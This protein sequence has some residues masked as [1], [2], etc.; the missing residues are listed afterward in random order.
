MKNSIF[1]LP[2]VLFLT[3]F[4]LSCEFEKEIQ[5]IDNPIN[6]TAELSEALDDIVD[7]TDVPGFAVTVV[8]GDDILFQEAFGYADVQARKR[9]TNETIQHIASVSKTFVGA[10]VVKAI[11]QGLF[12]LETNINDLLPV[13][14]INPKQPDTDIKVKHLVT[15]TSGLLDNAQLYT[16]NNYY[17]L[18]GE[19]LNTE[20]AQVMTGQLGI[21]QREARDLDEFLAEYFLADGD[22][23]R[24]DNFAN[25]A[26]GST[27]AYSNV[28]TGLM[29]LIIEA[30][31]GM[32]F[33]VYVKTEI[34][35]P[36]GMSR[37]T[38]DIAEADREHLARWYLDKNTP[39]PLYGN[40]SYVE[41]SLFTNN[42]DLG[43]FLLE[44]TGGAQGLSSKLFSQYGYNLLFADQLPA[45]VVPADF[46]DNHGVFWIKD[47]NY[48]KHGG[49][50][51]GVSAYI[52]LEKTG[53]AGYTFMTN[54]DASFDPTAYR[55]VAEKVDAVIKE[56]LSEN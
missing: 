40:D 36:L 53:N 22:L 42:E 27:W 43:E 13:E 7:E 14:V 17:I 38:Y 55:E 50:S 29:G 35:W 46:A 25:T 6:T 5:L 47:G 31:S 20:G 49:N 26:P 12:T 15:H 2:A 3:V 21:D 11:E 19:N 56:Y 48:L 52:E 4:T 37:S 23:Y 34:L 10:A 41:G 45:G 8:K 51:L 39:F 30:A 33:D 18:P 28:A 54:M 16:A 24:P 1:F 9:Y 44:M 32:P